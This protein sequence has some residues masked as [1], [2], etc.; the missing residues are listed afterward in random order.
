MTCALFILIYLFLSAAASTLTD[1]T[2][3]YITTFTQT[4][5]QCLLH[6]DDA[7]ALLETL[8]QKPRPLSPKCS[9]ICLD[10]F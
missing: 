1:T 2:P 5:T 9:Q 3:L 8:K 4:L 6:A 10:V 7:F